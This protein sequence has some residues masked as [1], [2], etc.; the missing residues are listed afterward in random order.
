[1]ERKNRMTVK[2]MCFILLLL[3]SHAAMIAQENYVTEKNADGRLK[4]RYDKAREYARANDFERALAELEK[5]LG[6]EPRFVDALIIRGAIYDEQKK[7]ALSEA[8]FEQAAQIAPFHEERVWYRLALSEMNQGKYEEAE[9]HFRQYLDGEPKSEQLRKQAADHLDQLQTIAELMRRPVPFEPVSL[10]DK[11]NTEESETLPSFT[12]DGQY[13]IYTRL[14][15]GQEDFFISEK[16]DGEWQEGQPLEDLNTPLNEGAQS[17]SADGRLLVFTSCDRRDGLGGC[18]LYFA[19]FRDGQWTRPAN[20][21]RPVNSAA[22]ESQPSLSAS[23]RQ[24][25]FASNRKGTIGGSDLWVSTLQP[26]GRWGEPQNLGREINTNRE[27]AA[28]FI[29][30]DSRTMY[31]MSEGHPGM[32]GFDLFV[33]RKD[34]EGRWGSVKNLGYPINTTGNEGALIVSLDGQTAYFTSNR[35]GRN[36]IYKDGGF[37]LFSFELYPEARPDPVTYVKAVVRDA[38][39]GAFLSATVEFIDLAAS[40]VHSSAVTAA[41]GGFLVCLPLGKDYSLNVSR[42]D[43]LFYSENFALTGKTS[44]ENPFLLNIELNRIPEK[45]GSPEMSKPK[46]VVLRN[47]FFE[48]ASAELKPASRIEL[49]RLRQLLEHNDQLRI[50]INGHTDNVGA[51]EANQRLSEA[52]AKAVYG[53]LIEK[54]IA[55]ERLQYKGFGESMPIAPNDTPEGRQQNRRTEFEVL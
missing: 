21:G 4:K 38:E 39:T 23:G 49:D 30:P 55:P 7:Y 32:G 25:Y 5:L 48:T 20:M 33:A 17:I 54:G 41:D 18:D 31:F 52:R 27:D 2:R 34:D 8:S 43:Y 37:D 53:Y 45:S 3:F 1:M 15:K 16:I 26:D 10:G 12:A 28:P 42:P 29:H 13:L 6:D 11:I 9:V 19:E 50:R 51:D 14:V 47:V 22:W 46:P 24:L 35:I 36:E 40:R 44:Q